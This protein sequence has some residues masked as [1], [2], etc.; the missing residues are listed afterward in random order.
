MAMGM[1]MLALTLAGIGTATKVV[2]DIKQTN[3]ANRANAAAGKAQRAA[4]ESQAQLADYNAGVAELQAQDAVARGSLDESR[5]RQNVRQVIGSQRA[6]MAAGNVDVG[7]GSA[8]D[9]QGDAA[10][11]GEL[12]ALTIRTN[13]AR[14]AWGYQVTAEDSRRKAAI[15]RK[16]GANLEAAGNV[17]QG[18]RL[19]SATSTILGGTASLLEAKYGFRKKDQAG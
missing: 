14:Q 19:L 12:D 3:A 6:G 7:Y 18:G 16:E 1:S 10:F 13:A 15:L 11:L 8:V 9:V 17:Q 5:F 4:S 2:G